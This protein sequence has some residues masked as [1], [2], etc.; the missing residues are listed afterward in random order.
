[1]P[2]HARPPGHLDVPVH[3]AHRVYVLH[4]VGHVQQHLHRRSELDADRAAGQRPVQEASLHGVTQRAAVA[5]LQA[6]PGAGAGRGR[7]GD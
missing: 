2:P 4:R 5:Q 1:M 6:G 7:G 3:E